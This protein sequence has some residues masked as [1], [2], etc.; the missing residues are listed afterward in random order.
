MQSSY[1]CIYAG[2]YPQYHTMPRRNYTTKQMFKFSRLKR[3]E[4]K[5]SEL[6]CHQHIGMIMR[7]RKTAPLTCHSQPTG[8]K[9]INKDDKV[10]C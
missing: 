3:K 7:Y 5:Y 8:K 9:I 1:P 2:N 10:L 4:R 6:I